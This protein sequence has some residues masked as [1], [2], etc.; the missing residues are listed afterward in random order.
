MRVRQASHAQDPLP[1]T[2]RHGWQRWSC[3]EIIQFNY[4]CAHGPAIGL[5]IIDITLLA[6]ALNGITEIL[7][8]GE[9]ERAGEQDHHG[10]LGVD[11]KDGIVDPYRFVL[12]VL[13]ERLNGRIHFIRL[14]KKFLENTVQFLGAAT[15]EITPVPST[16]AYAPDA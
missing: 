1:V 4:I 2:M 3:T 12:Q 14:W 5:H 8:G 16:Y 13:G 11:G 6:N 10:A 7:T 15:V 9:E